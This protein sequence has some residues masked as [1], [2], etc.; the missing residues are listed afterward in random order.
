M[1]ELRPVCIVHFGPGVPSSS[2][3]SLPEDAMSQFGGNWA[4]VEYHCAA[5]QHV[6]LLPNK[7]S[8]IPWQ[9]LI[10]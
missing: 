9:P 5:V 3:S 4:S 2:P 1:T 7:I 8:C 10:V 6:A